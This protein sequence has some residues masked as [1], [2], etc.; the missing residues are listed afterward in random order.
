MAT[1]FPDDRGHTPV[2]LGREYIWS[3]RFSVT[4]YK[5][6]EHNK[7]FGICKLKYDGGDF[8]I[9]ETRLSKYYLVPLVK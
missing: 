3:P 9:S 8:Y 1:H 4:K 5:L 6:V 2:L 7:E